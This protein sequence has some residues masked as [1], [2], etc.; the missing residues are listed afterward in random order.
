MSGFE[1][2]SGGGF[3]S[4]LVLYPDHNEEIIQFDL[5]FFVQLDG[6]RL[7]PTVIAFK[8]SLP[9]LFSHEP[10]FSHF[11]NFGRNG[12]K[13]SATARQGLLPS[14]QLSTFPMSF[15]CSAS[16]TLPSNQRPVVKGWAGVKFEDFQPW[17]NVHNV[18]SP[19]KFD[20]IESFF[21]NEFG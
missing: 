11:P 1:R 3:R 7:A 5:Y 17:A 15:V 18:T 13:T 8:S 6:K 14:F 10:V 16:T 9:H 12:S 2:C 21:S 4:Q 19:W 20:K